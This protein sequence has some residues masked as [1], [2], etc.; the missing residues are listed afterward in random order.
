MRNVFW[1]VVDAATDEERLTETQED[2]TQTPTSFSGDGKWLAFTDG[3]LA[4]GYDITAVRLDDSRKSQPVLA[5]QINEY[6]AQFSPDG[7]WIAYQSDESGQ[8]EVYVQSFPNPAAKR[9]ISTR[10]GIEPLWSPDGRKL[11]YLNGTK[12]MEVDIVSQPTFTAGT[13]RAVL[14]GEYAFSPTATTGYAVS[15]DGQRFLRLQPVAPDPPINQ[16]HVVLNWFEELKRLAPPT[17]L[18]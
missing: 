1:K 17:G 2:I 14:E 10:G 4:S 9:L 12:L 11:F 3:R 6:N 18:K 15:K 13:P 16:I 7:R 8:V 5:S